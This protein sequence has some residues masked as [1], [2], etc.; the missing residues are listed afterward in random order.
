MQVSYYAVHVQ[1]YALKKTKEKYRK[2]K[3]GKK[4]EPS[5]FMIPQPPLNVGIVDYA[6]MIED[7]DA[8]FGMLLNKIDELGITDNTY[9]IYTSDNGGGF[10]G[11]TPLTKGKAD[12]WEGGIRVPMVVRGPSVLA[13][14]YCDVPVVGWDFFPTFSDLISNP[15]PLPK[16]LDGGSLC[17]VFENGNN[18]RVRRG[19]EA[20][21][22]HFP[23]YNEEPESAIR[24]GNYKL[25]KNLDTRKLWLFNLAKDI[26]ES[27]NLLHSMP[28]KTEEL[29]RKLRDY[30]KAVDAEHVQTLRKN[31]RRRVIEEIIPKQKK[32]IKQ[33]RAKLESENK[34]VIFIDERSRMHSE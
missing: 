19:E 8:G 34:S 23:W 9:I 25:I 10:R 4:C 31:W 21:I 13:G 20:L 1:H 22:F 28:E 15:N 11:N 6:A 12:L 16:N 18:G 5:D 33:I 24:L 30:L 32:K 2:K 3:P 29:H 7:L 26:E 17:S 14:S 27:N